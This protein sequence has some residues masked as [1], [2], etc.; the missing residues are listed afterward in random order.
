VSVIAR[1]LLAMPKVA[2]VGVVTGSAH[3]P[4]LAALGELAVDIV[5]NSK[6]QEGIASSIRAA[7]RWAEA[8]GAEALLIT[9]VDQVHL[10]V[11][12]LEALVDAW[13]DGTPA[14]ASGYGGTLGVPALFDARTFGS[15]LTLEGDR[16]GARV[17]RSLEGVVV[18]PWEEGVVDVD[19]QDDVERWTPP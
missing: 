15:L 18:V 8:S 10:T 13:R 5:P 14:V 9:L 12:H 3:E 7:T 4:V 16:G 2:R 6:W 1:L 11:L 17:L 19:S